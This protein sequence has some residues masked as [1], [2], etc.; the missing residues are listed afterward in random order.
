MTYD[1]SSGDKLKFEYIPKGETTPIT[2]KF[3]SNGLEINGETYK[4]KTE[5]NN[6]RIDL[7]NSLAGV[8]GLAADWGLGGLVGVSDDFD[9]EDLKNIF[10][11][12]DIE[13][14]SLMITSGGI[15]PTGL[16]I[17]GKFKDKKTLKDKLKEVDVDGLE[18][19]VEK[20][21]I[22][23]T[24]LPEG[25]QRKATLKLADL[26]E[27][28]ESCYGKSNGTLKEV[29]GIDESKENDGTTVNITGD[30]KIGFEQVSA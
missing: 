19:N 5:A 21:I 20:G 24:V 2:C 8:G 28:L 30:F 22:E 14:T 3:S 13:I 10:T 17:R 12:K 11:F 9:P 18:I 29:K 6:L 27:K 26:F 4:F 15:V 25:M 7:E 16:K 1:F 23:M